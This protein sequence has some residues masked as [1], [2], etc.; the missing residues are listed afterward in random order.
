VSLY[1]S[2]SENASKRN[3]RSNQSR[4]AGKTD[5]G[6]IKARGVAIK[7]S[8]LVIEDRRE[9][10]EVRRVVL[11]VSALMI[12]AGEVAIKVSLVILSEGRRR[13]ERSLLLDDQE[14]AEPRL[15]MTRR[16][17][18][19]RPNVVSFR[20][21]RRSAIPRSNVQCRQ[22]A[23]EVVARRARLRVLRPE[24]LLEDAQG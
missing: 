7:V 20:P 19:H 22:D 1:F 2:L 10:I 5:I 24:L 4:P 16:F 21:F 9:M 11:E 17:E 15:S 6:M 13:S 12:E 8:A 3:L 18:H 14:G 23:R